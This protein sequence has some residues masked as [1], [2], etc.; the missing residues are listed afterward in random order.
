MVDHTHILAL[1]NELPTDYADRLGVGY[2]STISKGNKKGNG[3]FFTPAAIA[4]FMGELAD[5]KKGS[6]KILDPGSGTGVLSCALIE[7]L[8]GKNDGIRKIEIA[9]YE[10]DQELLPYAEKGFRYLKKW[11]RTKK[12]DLK[13]EV[14]QRDFILDN[15]AVFDSDRILNL[16][17]KPQPEKYDFIISNP[18][19]F[20]LSKEDPRTH[21]SG[22]VVSG[23]PNIYALFMAVASMLLDDNGQ[24]IFIVPRSFA[25]GN[26]F[27]AFRE[28][29]FSNI[30]VTRIHLFHSRKDTFHRDDVLQELLVIKGIPRKSGHAEPRIA[31][32]TSY[33]S[34]DLNAVKM[35]VYDQRDLIN[36]HSR[37]KIL[38]LPTNGSEVAVINQFR[39]WTHKLRD[40]N[41]EISTGPVVAFRVRKHIKDRQDNGKVPLAPLY[42]LHNVV[43]MNTEWPVH[44]SGKGQYI[45]I[46]QEARSVLIPNR[47]Y[48]LLRRFSAK[49]DKS[50]LIAAPH[51]VNPS[52]PEYIGIENKL[53]YIYRPKG[54][55]D[56]SEAVGLAVLLNSK[57]FDTYFRTFNGNVNVSATELREMTFPPLE[58]IKEIG[59]TFI[60]GNGFSVSKIDNNVEE[61]LTGRQVAY[62]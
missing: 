11:L 41:I 43:K 14:I 35:K 49:D 21:V 9:A 27:R 22:V 57:L 3:Q 32:S 25:S 5:S 23:Q 26:Y 45:E 17:A 2:S 37:E 24:L 61:F 33:G 54:N 34:K 53:N 56:R 60:A 13:Y 44:K 8:V 10:T 30:Q 18:P 29:F 48:V 62:A 55:L 12:V 52:E 42:W 19:Y 31:I 7:H 59:N 4:R 16:F 1:R 50:R 20:K 15:G 38:H 47:N 51:F 46:C 6:I 28:F 36:L 40:F 39:A 58:I